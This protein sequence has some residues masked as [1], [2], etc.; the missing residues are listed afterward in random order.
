MM[1]MQYLLEPCPRLSL[2]RVIMSPPRP[3]TFAAYLC[4][5]AQVASVAMLVIS[6]TAPVAA[7]SV[8]L[9]KVGEITGGRGQAS[10]AALPHRTARTSSVHTLLHTC[11]CPPQV[12][13]LT[14]Q[15][16]QDLVRQKAPGLMESAVRQVGGGKE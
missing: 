6:S 7:T 2:V 5:S 4:S 14:P 15:H 8:K 13:G 1:L 12:S 10:S 9:H 11:P 16:S 3:S